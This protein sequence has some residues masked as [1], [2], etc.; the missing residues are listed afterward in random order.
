MD[1]KFEDVVSAIKSASAKLPDLAPLEDWADAADEFAANPNERSFAHL[2]SVSHSLSTNLRG[3]GIR[4]TPDR[5][6]VGAAPQ[7]AEDVQVNSYI[8]KRYPGRQ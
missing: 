3:V 8:A 4:V 6:A 1:D 2:T 7:K 5:L